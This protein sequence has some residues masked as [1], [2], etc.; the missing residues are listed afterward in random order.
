VKRYTIDEITKEEYEEIGI[1][2]AVIRRLMTGV[3]FVE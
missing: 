2:E 1:P 3:S